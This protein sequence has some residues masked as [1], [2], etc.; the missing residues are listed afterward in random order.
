[1]K[2]TLFTAVILALSL[3]HTTHSMAQT[4]DDQP[5]EEVFQTELVYPQD[6]GA[7]QFTSSFTFNKANNEFSNDLTIEYG[8]TRSWQID[9]EWQSFARK[10]TF[11]GQSLRGSGDL[12]LGTK[13]SFMNILGSNFHGAVGFELGLPAASAKKGISED[14]IEYEPFVIVAKDFPGLSRLQLFSQLGLSFSHSIRESR[15]DE[16][17]SNEKIVEWSSGMFVPYRRARFTTAF[18]WSKSS[19]E[20]SLYLTPGLVWK[21]PRDLEVGAGVPIGL[22]RDAD[23]FRI[24]AH[25][26]YEFGGARGRE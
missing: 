20:S 1:M 11:D 7:F 13:Y 3:G 4:S 5:L 10:K 25:V 22:T 9:L 19:S 2:K 16:N 23:P 18:S 14:K 24:V 6:K 15:S 8:L 12:R 17:D 21:L 26:V